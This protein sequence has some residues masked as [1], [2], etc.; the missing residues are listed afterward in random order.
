MRLQ[1]HWLKMYELQ[2]AGGARGKVT[3]SMES[4]VCVCV[5]Q[6][7]SRTCTWTRAG[8]FRQEA[9]APCWPAVAVQTPSTCW[10]WNICTVSGF[11]FDILRHLNHVGVCEVNMNI[12]HSYFSSAEQQQQS[13]WET[14]N[15]IYTIVVN[16]TFF[17]LSTRSEPLFW[18]GQTSS[19]CR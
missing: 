3:G 12:T 9:A 13:E 4:S 11:Y 5:W 17:L 18:W 2:P 8:E 10:S 14:L 1:P 19:T 7:E 16:I 6:I 15:F